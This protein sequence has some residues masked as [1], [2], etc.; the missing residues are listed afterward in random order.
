MECH[1]LKPCPCVRKARGRGGVFVEQ[2][3]RPRGCVQGVGQPDRSR[4]APAQAIIAPLSVQ[5]AGGGMIKVVCAFAANILQRAADRL[6]GGDAAGGD[7]RAR[8]AEPFVGKAA[9]RRSIDPRSISST[10]A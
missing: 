3:A 8:R 10:A 4:S 5:S 9:S 6:V 7:Q 1:P 2:P